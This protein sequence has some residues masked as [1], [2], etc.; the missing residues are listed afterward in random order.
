[1]QPEEVDCKPLEWCTPCGMAM[2]QVDVTGSLLLT[3][4]RDPWPQ[5]ATVNS[6]PVYLRMQTMTLL[7]EVQQKDLVTPS[8][9]LC[10]GTPG[11]M[12][13]C[14]LVET[15]TPEALAFYRALPHITAT[16]SQ[17]SMTWRTYS[18]TRRCL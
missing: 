14:P 12:A 16:L 6:E 8:R 10:E 17:D 13:A 11:E 4:D 9:K 18:P 3:L 7:Y 2:R 5:L 15:C 1:M